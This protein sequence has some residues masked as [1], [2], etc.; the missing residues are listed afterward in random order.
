MRALPLAYVED[1]EA[2]ERLCVLNANSTSWPF[3]LLK[4][5]VRGIRI[6][7]REPQAS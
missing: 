6:H 5:R 4:R 1:A 2:R 3:G 7:V